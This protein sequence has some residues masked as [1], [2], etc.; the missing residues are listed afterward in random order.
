NPIWYISKSPN[1]GR[2]YAYGPDPRYIISVAPGQAQLISLPEGPAKSWNAGLFLN[3]KRISRDSGS[4]IMP[5]PVAAPSMPP[6]RQ[7]PVMPEHQPT[8]PTQQNSPKT[9]PAS[10]TDDLGAA[11]DAN[12]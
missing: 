4:C 7:A 2:N 6:A 8:L 10:A 3:N 12:Q 1:G 11:F 5:A 9:T